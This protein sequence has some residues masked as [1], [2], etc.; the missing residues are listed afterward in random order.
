MVSMVKIDAQN[1]RLLVSR[2]E[3]NRLE[4][5]NSSLRKVDSLPIASPL[6]DLVW[7]DA[8]NYLTLEMG[9]MDPSDSRKGNLK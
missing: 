3:N 9:I 4:M 7:L 6:S 2:R 8:Q 5:Y 1:G